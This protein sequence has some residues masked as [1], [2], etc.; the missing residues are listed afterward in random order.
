MECAIISHRTTIVK[1]AELHVNPLNKLQD[2]TFYTKPLWME[3]IPSLF[4]ASCFVVPPLSTLFVAVAVTN[5]RH[6]LSS[7][8][9]VEWGPPELRQPVRQWCPPAI[10]APPTRRQ[11]RPPRPYPRVVAHCLHPVL[12]PP[13]SSSPWSSPFQRALYSW[14]SP[15]LPRFLY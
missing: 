7:P 6:A 14:N 5:W 3:Q 12:V 15:T 1:H 9:H 4:V 2:F 10:P 8:S 13:S 11:V